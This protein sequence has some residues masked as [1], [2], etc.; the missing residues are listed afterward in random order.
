MKDF[1]NKLCV[2]L[3]EEF[4]GPIIRRIGNSLLY[5]TKTIPAIC[6][7]TRLPKRK[8][9]EGLS[10]LIKYGFVTY[11]KKENTEENTEYTLHQSK[12]IMIF[13]YPRYMLFAKTYCGDEGE[14][15]LEEVLKQGFITA[16]EVIMKTYKRIEYAPSKSTQPPSIPNLKDVFE[17]LV[18][19]QFLMR[20]TSFETMAEDSKK[21]NYNLP[22]LDLPAISNAL[23]GKNAELTDSK[24]YWKVNF[25]RLTQDLRDQIVISA[26]TQKFD[27]NAGELMR[28]LINLMYLRTASWADTSNPIPYTE[29]K[30]EVKKL[31]YEELEHYLDQYLRLL[32]EDSTQFIKRVGDSGGGQYSVN[33]KNAFKQLT[34][35]TLEHIVTER[36]G[37]KAARIF[38]LLRYELDVNLE[39]IQNLAMIPA[40]EA[41]F[42]TYVLSQENY[43]QTHE[44]KKSAYS[45]LPPK[46]IPYRFCIDLTKI[47]EMEIEHCYQA[48]YNI[49]TRREHESASNKRMIEK[50]L[51]VQILSA[52]LKEHGATE[53]Q[54]AD[55]AEMMTPSETEQLEKA[56]NTI[57]KLSATESQIDETLFLLTMYFRYH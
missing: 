38:R 23:Q 49:M 37:S 30:E 52:N 56:Q 2:L 43:I 15:M 25:D 12:I 7:G 47:V 18:K 54:L 19:N 10:V 22:N 36:F 42:L 3:L 44:M 9:K 4:L 28:Q 20:N 11:H 50:Q 17:L 40:K 45:L 24:I 41:K 53:Q 29:I 26:V 33:M 8:I 46:S 14:I 34:W 21:P 51:R 31:N 5:G 1:Y 55:I 16:S 39:Q 57:K 48:L 6:Y 13:R 27:K 35:A 32:E